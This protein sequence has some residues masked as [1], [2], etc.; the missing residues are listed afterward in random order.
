[1]LGSFDTKTLVDPSELERSLFD[2]IGSLDSIIVLHTAHCSNW[3]A[4]IIHTPLKHNQNLS[5]EQ[6]GFNG[7]SSRFSTIGDSTLRQ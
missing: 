1:M 5:Q 3:S 6:G 4:H 2:T 7:R